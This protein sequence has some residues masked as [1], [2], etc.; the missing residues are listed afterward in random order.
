MPSE[1][2]K[3]IYAGR[4]RRGD[5]IDVP[6]FVATMPDACPVVSICNNL[7]VVVVLQSPKIRD[8]VFN[9]AVYLGSLFTNDSYL[10][11]IQYS[12]GSG[13]ID[14]VAFVGFD[15]LGGDAQG[16]VINVH[17]ASRQRGVAVI[18]HTEDARIRLAYKTREDQ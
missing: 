15:V 4:F 6:L 11:I 13:A 10:A 1:V 5:T 8:N 16:S 14:H 2:H 7:G 18:R 12:T 17:S 3:E 9:L